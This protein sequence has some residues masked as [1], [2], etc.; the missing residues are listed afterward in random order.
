MPRLSGYR[1]TPPDSAGRKLKQL[2]AG[3]Q[4][5]IRARDKRTNGEC[6]NRWD[7]GFY[8]SS[9]NL[10]IAGEIGTRKLA[11]LVGAKNPGFAV[12]RRRFFERLR[13]G[14]GVYC[15]RQPPRQ[16]HSM[17]TIHDGHEIEEATACRQIDDLGIPDEVRLLNL[18]I[19]QKIRVTLVTLRRRRRPGLWTKR[20]SS[21]Y[22]L[23]S[24]NARA[25]DLVALLAQWQ[26]HS[27]R[28]V[29]RPVREQLTDLRQREPVVGR[30]LRLIRAR[31]R[32]ADQRALP[33]P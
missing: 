20:G 1:S 7:F 5:S 25:N 13:T 18:Q 11:T 8:F 23:I 12:A 10:T 33:P 26:S 9:A 29:R 3:S 17:G 4:Q 14:C 31:L 30:L 32:H 15:V 16:D 22:T 19:M 6:V 27:S 21:Y 28:A 2:D 24:L